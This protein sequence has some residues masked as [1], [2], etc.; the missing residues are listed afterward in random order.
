MGAGR[1][2][3]FLMRHGHV[4]YFAADVTD[5]TAVPLTDEGRNQAAAARDA[6]SGIRFDA[7]FHSGLP[8][9]QETAQI[10]LDK[11]ASAPALE[12]IDDL[13][14]LKSGWLQAKSREELA[15]RLAYSFDGAGQPGARFLP[16]GEFFLDAQTR[17]ARG[18]STIILERDWKT[19]LVVAHE[20]VNRVALAWMIGAGLNTI[21]SFEQDLCGVNVID[22]DVV[23]APGGEGLHIERIV[24]RALNVTP[25]DYVKGRL[26]RSNLE[27][28]FGVDFGGPRPPMPEL[29]QFA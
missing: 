10:V 21:G 17:I 26:E 12:A 28:L 6:L 23:P 13:H 11:Q 22:I 4:D 9:A 20:G 16:D 5:P 24:L 18:L 2:R 1:R 8:R 29:D 19:A 27:H 15:A 14:E 3:M 25:Y 7:A